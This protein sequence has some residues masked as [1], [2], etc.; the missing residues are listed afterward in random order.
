MRDEAVEIVQPGMERRRTSF[1]SAALR[2]QSSRST[3]S[4]PFVC[5]FVLFAKVCQLIHTR[6]RG[7]SVPRQGTRALP[8]DD[9][10]DNKAGN[11][12]GARQGQ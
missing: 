3:A 7:H 8:S 6:G 10:P 9:C 1:P 4:G 2:H 5:A 11:R 12:E